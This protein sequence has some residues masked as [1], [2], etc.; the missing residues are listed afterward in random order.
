MVLAFDPIEEARK[1]WHNANWPA[2]DFM[3]TATAIT[4]AHQIVLGRMNEA[5][6]P[7]GLTLSRF[8]ALA[9]L[10]FTR[11][12]AMP[13]GRLGDRLQVH[14]ASVT[15]TVD[16][17]EN[18]GLV[19]RASHAADRRTV[20]ASITPLGREVVEAAAESLGTISFGVAELSADQR[21]RLDQSLR[22][23]RS[24]AGDFADDPATG[25]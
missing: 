17:L 6:A 23:L 24:A 22:V 5:L 25:N 7:H 15:N 11:S 2:G 10:R 3:A 4:R 8:E 19:T 16:R 12:G 13:L 18:D 21:G 9:V 1:N 20:L 14:P